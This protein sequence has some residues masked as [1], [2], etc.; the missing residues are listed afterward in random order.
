MFSAQNVTSMF[1]NG[2]SKNCSFF[3]T[4]F[5]DKD[6]PRFVTKKWIEVDDQS[7]KNCYVNK[8]IKV[9]T[10]MLRSYVCDFSDPYIVVKGDIIVTNPDDAKRHKSVAFKNNAPFIN[11]ISEINGVQINNAEDL[12]VVMPMYNMFEY[13]K[14]YKKTTRSLWNYYRDQPSNPLSST[15]ESFKCKTGITENT[16]DVGAGEPGWVANKGKHGSENVILLKH[17]INIWRTLNI[18]L[19][20]FEIK[21]I[22]T[23]SKNCALVD[24]TVRAAGNNNDPPAI[25][26]PTGLEFQITHTKLHVLVL[27]LSKENDKKVLEQL[28]SGFKRTTTRNKYRSQMTV[29]SNN[30]NLNYLIDS[31]FTKDNRLFVL[32][33]ERIEEKNVKKYHRDSFSPYCTPNVKIKDFNVLINGKSFFDLPVKTEEGAYKKLTHMSRNNDCTTGNLLDFAY[34]KENYRLIAIDLSEQTELKAT[35]I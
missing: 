22:L 20:N 32:S 14:N 13:S 18:P 10:P 31:T 26:T 33:F 17:L 1:K 23:W 35:T 29:Q 24:M 7:E 9:K 21:L 2:I 19:I 16:Y 5:D 28:K 15:S 27:T 11:C 12:D 4:D 3:D 8:E 34:F 25:V 6:L 30:N